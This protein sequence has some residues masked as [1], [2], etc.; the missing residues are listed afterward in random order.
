MID[1]ILSFSVLHFH[2]NIY[3]NV[4]IRFLLIY[5]SELS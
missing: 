2:F 5:I 1:L 4:R 3:L